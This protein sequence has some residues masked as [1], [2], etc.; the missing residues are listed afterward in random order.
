MGL[1][2]IDSIIIPLN[3]TQYA[4][5]LDQYLDASVVQFPVD[6]FETDT[7]YSVESLAVQETSSTIDFG[8]LRLAIS[9]LQAASEALDEEKEDAEKVSKNDAKSVSTLY[10]S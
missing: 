9:K 6:M 2:L 1:R 5:E 3:T 10:S 7:F 8:I 4:F